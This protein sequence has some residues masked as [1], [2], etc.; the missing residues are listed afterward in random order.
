[1]SE[2]KPKTEQHIL[3][4]H[5]GP[6]RLAIYDKDD[7]LVTVW[8]QVKVDGGTAMGELLD[9]AK[10]VRERYWGTGTGLQEAIEQLDR[11]ITEAGGWKE[12]QPSIAKA[13]GK[14]G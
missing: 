10:K 11:A 14:H 4:S 13:E 2:T 1:M 3:L 7:E 9:A 12:P 5:R 8:T 6:F